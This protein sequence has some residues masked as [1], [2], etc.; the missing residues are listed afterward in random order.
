MSLAVF[1]AAF[2][3]ILPAIFLATCGD[4]FGVFTK[5]CQI[6]KSSRL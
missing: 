6:V 5:T 4:F 2:A 1:P 3:T